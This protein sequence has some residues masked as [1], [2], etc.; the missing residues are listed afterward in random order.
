MIELNHDDAL[1][2]LSRVQDI[3]DKSGKTE[4]DRALSFNL[5]NHEFE[6]ALHKPEEPILLAFEV[7]GEYGTREIVF[8]PSKSKA[9]KDSDAYADGNAFFALRTKR[10]PELDQYAETGLPDDFDQLKAP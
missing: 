5:I 3:I 10:R 8:A 6:K 4:F 7:I 2:L 1:K 9:K